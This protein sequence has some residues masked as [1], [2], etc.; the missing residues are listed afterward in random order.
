MP[1]SVRYVVEPQELTAHK[2]HVRIEV[3]GVE[4]AREQL[5]FVMPVWSPGSYS[6]H[7][8]ARAI[9][10]A[11]AR[12]GTGDALPVTK[13]SKNRWRVVPGGIDQMVFSYT[14]YGH[15]ST[16]QGL[17]VTTDHIHLNAAHAL[18]YVD[19][20]LTQPV[21]V[22]IHPPDDWKVFTE[23]S[24]I[25]RNPPRYRAK[26]FDELVDS[27]VEVG[28]PAE[29]TIQP[30]GVPHRILFCGPVTDIP[31]HQ[32]QEDLAKVV[33]ATK[34]LFGLLPV[35]HY[36][37]FYHLAEK[38]DGGLEHATSTSIVMPHDI[39]RPRKSYDEFLEV[40]SHEYFHLFNVKR[41]RPKV[42]GPFD[43]TQE[44]YTHL[45]WLMEG[46]TEYY[47][48]LLLRRSGLKTPKKYLD[49]IAKRVKD[50]RAI[51]GRLA[52]SLEE[53]SFDSWI[54]LYKP[55]EQS[56]NASVSYYL[57]GELVTL[58]LDLEIRA[59]SGNAKSF[60]DVMRHLW[61]EYGAKGIGMA[62]NTL[63]AE[64]EQ[65]TGVDVTD[66]FRD[67]VSGKAELDLPR[68]L[69]LAGLEL[70]P[71][72]KPEGK[73][74][75]EGP[76]AWLGVET[77]NF[78]GLPRIRSVLDGSPALRAGLSPG[79]ILVALGGMRLPAAKMGDVMKRF[80]PGEEATVT[81]FR[82]GRL[83]SVEA[84]LGKPPPEKWAFK[85]KANPTELEKKILESW[86]Q[87][88]WDDLPK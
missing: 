61:R 40:S 53:S 65:A 77:E 51:P 76:S 83:R 70:A 31:A 85:P 28:R 88:S 39:F 78:D 68:H 42:L 41:I 38:W 17:D 11:E 7:E 15:E 14:V 19:G 30:A 50:L 26:D 67:Y 47:G 20:T 18:C 45:L 5:D 35:S 66:L 59:R 48:N 49:L 1:L 36:T 79:D 64:I 16:S 80:E 54:D 81:F 46:G 25:G 23:L 33:E 72:E 8:N 73:E 84:K 13:V 43:Y 62:E 60:D 21:E 82:Q 69:A 3:A 55:W 58:C 75:E 52:Q 12:N 87:C 32:V 34:Q 9:R 22:T 2:L 4:K 29:F 6:I 63:P 37:F 57:K 86:L 27:P 71:E 56:R 10:G 24:E 74:D 44:N